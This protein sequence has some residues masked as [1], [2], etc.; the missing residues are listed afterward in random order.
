MHIAL[1]GT[2]AD[3]PTLGHQTILHW[4][5]QRFDIVAIW[6]SDNP[7]KSGQTPM[8]H[9]MQMLKLL[10]EDTPSEHPNIQ[11]R[12][13][14]SSPRT[15][16]S[17]Q[18]AQQIWPHAKFTIVVGSDL[19]VQLPRWYQ[20]D[21]WITSVNL[22]IIPRPGSPVAEP[23]LAALHQLGATVTI[24]PIMGLDT[25][26]SNYRNRGDRHNVSPAIQ[27]Y[28]HQAQLYPCQDVLKEKQPTH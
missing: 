24:A 12:S 21:R 9:R 5:S 27:A 25:S 16:H 11:L 3:P 10:I 4:L 7:F 28:I 15:L 23:A 8:H 26:S 14:L 13:E 22:L 18:A 17:V 2:S 1:F 19:I 6:A 20:V